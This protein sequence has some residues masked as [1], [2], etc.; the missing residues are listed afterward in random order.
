MRLEAVRASRFSDVPDAR[1]TW[2]SLAATVTGW[3]AWRR[4]GR[5]G[6]QQNRKTASISAVLRGNPFIDYPSC[7]VAS[8]N[9]TLVGRSTPTP[10][11]CDF[12]LI[13][14]QN[15]CI[16]WRCASV[17]LALIFSLA[18]SVEVLLDSSRIVIR[19]NSILLRIPCE[20]TLCKKKEEK[21]LHACVVLFGPDLTISSSFLD[22]IQFSGVKSAYRD[23]AKKTH[24]DVINNSLSTVAGNYDFLQVRE[25]YEAL[26]HYLGQRKST[27]TQSPPVFRPGQGGSA[28]ASCFYRY[29]QHDEQKDFSSLPDRRLMFGE[30]LFHAGFC[31]WRE[32]FDALAWQRQGRPR[33]GEIGCNFGWINKQDIYSIFRHLQAGIRFG[34]TAVHMGLLTPQQLERLLRHQTIRQQKIGQFFLQNNLLSPRQLQDALWHFNKHNFLLRQ[35]DS[36]R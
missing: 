34:E 35:R 20:M 10:C 9:Y 16:L 30:F 32:V 11:L 27:S 6:W 33:L 28:K 2:Q 1:G 12:I 19:F 18:Q 3:P 31:E 7:C 36:N 8:G 21:L 24:P 23:R 14:S 4:A 5:H 25:S 13:E 26:C 29:S 17:C 15:N 22:Y